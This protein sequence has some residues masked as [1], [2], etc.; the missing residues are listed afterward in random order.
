MIS[1]EAAETRPLARRASRS[2]TLE[3]LGDETIAFA[4]PAEAR[5]L[6]VA[7]GP[8]HASE[9]CGARRWCTCSTNA[10]VDYPAS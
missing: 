7:R 8:R 3:R 9:G 10:A 1:S 4:V 5:E 2:E 6:L